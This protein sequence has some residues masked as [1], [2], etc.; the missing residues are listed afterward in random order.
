MARWQTAAKINLASFNRLKLHKNPIILERQNG[1]VICHSKRADKILNLFMIKNGKNSL[2]KEKRKTLPVQ[3]Q[4]VFSSLVASVKIATF[5]R[6]VKMLIDLI[7]SDGIPL[8][9]QAITN[10][11][12][13]A[14]PC[15]FCRD[16]RDRF[17][18]WPE[19]DRY[20]CRQC[21]KSG[22][23]IQYLRDV[24]SMDFK[25]AAEVVGK[26]TSRKFRQKAK[27]KSATA[28]ERSSP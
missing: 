4:K 25:A 1:N 21:N 18:V 24:R 6:E 27:R 14:G 8:N 12:E 11:G 28:P 26:V 2:L 22:D 9:R 15:P 16:G 10:G 5:N 19:K 20:W 23:S 17:R 3:R 7:Q 13:Y